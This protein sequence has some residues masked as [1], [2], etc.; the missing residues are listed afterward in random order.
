METERNG[1]LFLISSPDPWVAKLC[2]PS[3]GQGNMKFR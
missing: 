3:V 2:I 1:V